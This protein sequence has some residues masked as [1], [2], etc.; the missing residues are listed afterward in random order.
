[1]FN[2]ERF[3]ETMDLEKNPAEKELAPGYPKGRPDVFIGGVKNKEFT[4]LHWSRLNRAFEKNKKPL[5]SNE[6]EMEPPFKYK[7]TTAQYD[8]PTENL[9]N[10]KVDL[11]SYNDKAI[12]VQGRIRESNGERWIC[13]SKIIDTAGPL[14]TEICIALTDLM[15]DLKGHPYPE[16]KGIG[17][18]PSW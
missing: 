18:K 16:V 12:M 8:A 14:L 11:S 7:L 13:E 1:M 3:G 2:Y 10:M 15:F 4:L 5:T 17:R 6:L 9:Q